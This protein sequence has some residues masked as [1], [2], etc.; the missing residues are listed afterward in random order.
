MATHGSI[1]PF[2]MA[3]RATHCPRWNRYDTDWPYDPMKTEKE[4][5]SEKFENDEKDKIEKKSWRWYGN[6][7]H[8][9]VVLNDSLK[10]LLSQS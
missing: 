5:G 10:E 6:D 3:W 4:K 7:E 9:K 1:C 2:C 8:D